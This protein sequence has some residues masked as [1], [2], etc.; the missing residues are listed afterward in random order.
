MT[1]MQRIKS[2]SNEEELNKCGLD[3]SQSLADNDIKNNY[4][5]IIEDRRKELELTR[6]A[7]VE[8]D[9][10][11]SEYYYNKQEDIKSYEG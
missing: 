4:F 9:F 6:E 11:K 2:A 8:F 3:T 1:L 10:D 7:I 5:D